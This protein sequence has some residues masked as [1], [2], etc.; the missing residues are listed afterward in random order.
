MKK[1]GM[2]LIMLMS[3]ILSACGT[4]AYIEEKNS[5]DV[6]DVD[7]NNKN[8][9]VIKDTEDTI[10]LQNT[11]AD[12]FV[13]GTLNYTIQDCMVYKNLSDVGIDMDALM[14]PHN[15]YYSQDIGEQ[16][17]TIKDFVTEDGRIVDSHELVVLNVKIQ[18]ENALGLIKKNEFTV[19]NIALRGGE[20]VSQYNI[21][22]F[23]QA[24]M[25][26]KEQPLHYQLEQGKTMEIQIAYFVLKEDVENIVGVISDS[27]V[28]FFIK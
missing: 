13:D 11:F 5:Q 9:I 20:N 3:V 12:P 15:I 4:S 26:D 21:A 14:E 28:Q 27:D 6:V 2:F 23:N 18:N 19:S 1:K 8:K 17:Q 24:G 7:D 25:L 10:K 16:Y 22:Y